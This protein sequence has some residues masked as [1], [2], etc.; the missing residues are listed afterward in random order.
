LKSKGKTPGEADEVAAVLK[1]VSVVE[2][3]LAVVPEYPS[4]LAEALDQLVDMLLE[5][6]L[7]PQLPVCAVVALTPIWRRSNDAVNTAGRK[8]F[9]NLH[10]VAAEDLIYRNIRHNCPTTAT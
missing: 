7:K 9:G 4:H 6:L 2:K 5:S 10:P 1:F 3:K 8:L